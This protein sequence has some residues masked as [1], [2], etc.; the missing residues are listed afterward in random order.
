MLNDGCSFLCEHRQNSNIIIAQLN[1]DCRQTETGLKQTKHRTEHNGLRGVKTPARVHAERTR[2]PHCR[3]NLIRRLSVDIKTDISHNVE[4]DSTPLRDK[5]VTS[6][7]QREHLM[8]PL[9]AE[10]DKI[11]RDIIL[12]IKTKENKPEGQRTQ[13]IKI[14]T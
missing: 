4:N 7:T 13:T 11:K 14:Q 10:Q 6:N 3:E 5:H 1:S 8:P 9:S 12:Q 2:L